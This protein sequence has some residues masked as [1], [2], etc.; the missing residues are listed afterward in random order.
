MDQAALISYLVQSFREDAINAV[1][2]PAD[3]QSNHVEITGSVE[4]EGAEGME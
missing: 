4:Q 3:S 2:H 1:T